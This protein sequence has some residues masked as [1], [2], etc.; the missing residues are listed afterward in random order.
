MNELKMIDLFAGVGGL[1][2]GFEQTGF[3]VLIANEFD[4]SIAEAYIKNRK[5]SNMIV[6]D[7]TR[8]PISETFGKYKGQ[9]TLVI[10]GPPCQG[11]S[12]KG[13]RKTIN[14]PRNFLFKY[15]V[16][17]VKEV[18]PQYFVMENVPNLLT[19]EKGF[20]KHELEKLFT[21]LGYTIN[22][23]VLC[24]ADYGVPQN[25]HR[26]FIIGKRGKCQ[27]EMPK[28]I[29]RRTTIW[30]AISDLAYLESGEGV[31]VADYQNKPAT[32]YQK[33]LRLDSDKLYN[34]VATNH[35]PVALE[36]LA[37]IPPK[38]GKEYLPPEHI[39][40]SIYSGTWERMDENDISVTI[41]TRFDTPSSGKFTHPY[42]D[43]AI[44]VREAARIQSF[45][46]SF[47]FFGTKTSQ[48]KQVGNAVPPLLAK[49]VAEAILEDMIN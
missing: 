20:F 3:E 4:E 36:R 5:N 43:R 25:R 48:M 12:Q 46:D 31:E 14:D 29:E 18:A 6:E 10:G 40:K 19:T 21:E 1:S 7:I 24:A 33:R 11:Y 17:V 30:E 2:L 42:L 44:T 28:K 23:Q 41:T 32:E 45:P 34:H 47:H 16:E 9:A 38:G 27:V 8:L 49:A 37:M 22:A 15:F 26:A 35:S 13:Q 39:T